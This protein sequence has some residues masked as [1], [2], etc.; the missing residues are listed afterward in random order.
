MNVIPANDFEIF[1]IKYTEIPKLTTIIKM[2]VMQS[3]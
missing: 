3:K 2:L 1:K